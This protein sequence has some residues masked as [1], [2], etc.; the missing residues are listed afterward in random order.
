MIPDCNQ[1]GLIFMINLLYCLSSILSICTH[2]TT[3][4]GEAPVLDL[5]RVWNI[6]LQPFYAGLL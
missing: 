4:D 6:L 1:A 5:W 3:S 2:L